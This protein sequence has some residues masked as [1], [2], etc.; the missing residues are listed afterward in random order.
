MLCDSY[1]NLQLGLVYD[2]SQNSPEKGIH[3]FGTF[4]FGKKSMKLKT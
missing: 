3:I 1:E 4:S 2:N